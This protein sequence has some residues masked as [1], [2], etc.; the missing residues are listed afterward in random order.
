MAL[1]ASPVTAS[2]LQHL[3]DVLLSVSMGLREELD[4]TSPATIRA[5]LWRQALNIPPSCFPLS[6][7]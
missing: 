5:P 2:G 7:I 3:M 1:V 4:A 6:W